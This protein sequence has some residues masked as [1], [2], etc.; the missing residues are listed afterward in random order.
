VLLYRQ[1]FRDLAY[2]FLK[3]QAASNVR[4]VEMFFDPQA[5]TLRK[6]PH[7][8]ENISFETVI[9]GLRQGIVEA[10][11]DFGI[12]CYLI[13][14]FLRHLPEESAIETFHQAQPFKDWIIGV[15]LDSGEQGNPPEKFARVFKLC[16]EIGWRIVGHAGEE[17]PAEYIWQMLR[18]GGERIEHGVAARTDG[19]LLDYLRDNRIPLTMC[20][21][22]SL[23]LKVVNSLSDYPF[24]DFLD[25]GICAGLY[26]DDPAYFGAYVKQVLIRTQAAQNLT[27]EHLRQQSVNGWEG[28]FLPAELKAQ[29]IAEVNEFYKKAMYG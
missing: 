17:G 18:L 1:D 11:R 7:T 24:K 14:C 29:R 20:S 21:V 19:K 10:Q 23:R 26:S 25:F 28:S 12:S 3:K 22:S 4:H 13:M 16:K 6:N 8:G 5:H 15:G 27:P 9:T 2:R